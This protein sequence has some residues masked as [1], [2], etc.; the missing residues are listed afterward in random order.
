MC[1]AAGTDA[2]TKAGQIFVKDDALGLALWQRQSGDR[3]GKFHVSPLD[4]KYFPGWEDYGKTR[5]AFSCVLLLTTDCGHALIFLNF[6]ALCL[7]LRLLRCEK[8]CRGQSGHRLDM[9]K[10]PLMTQSGHCRVVDTS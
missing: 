8:R 6:S 3:F 2:Q 7:L 1:E 5:P 9:R 10:C 4:R